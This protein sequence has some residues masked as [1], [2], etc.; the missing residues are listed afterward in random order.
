M[1]INDNK[2]DSMHIN[3]ETVLKLLMEVKESVSGIQ[4]QMKS[5]DEK[6][7]GLN[8]DLDKVNQ[9]A[10]EAKDIAQEAKTGN[11]SLEQQLQAKTQW[12]FYALIPILATV[13]PTLISHVHIK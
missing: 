9:V 11:E 10:T 7:S 6:V 5:I 3:Q 13:I 8:E 4:S 2:D 1:E 12:L